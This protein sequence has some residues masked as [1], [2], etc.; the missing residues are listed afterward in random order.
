M[1]QLYFD[2][3]APG[4]QCHQTAAILTDH[5]KQLVQRYENLRQQMLHINKHSNPHQEWVSD[6]QKLHDIFDIQK[7]I[8]NQQVDRLLS[9]KCPPSWADKTENDDRSIPLDV[10]TLFTEDGGAVKKHDEAKETAW[11]DIARRTQ[12]DIR[13][14]M[15]H[16]GEG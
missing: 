2:K 9:K 7:T 3:L 11:T 1:P 5:S 16:L 6:C 10:W 8:T 14:L 15:R 4:H 12:S 13:R